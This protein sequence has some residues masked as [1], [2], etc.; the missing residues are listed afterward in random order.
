MDREFQRILSYAKKETVDIGNLIE[1]EN[2]EVEL[3]EPQSWTKYLTQSI[4]FMWNKGTT[5]KI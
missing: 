5:G 4:V 2:K 1:S 3:V